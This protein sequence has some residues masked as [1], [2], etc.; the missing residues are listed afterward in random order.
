[1][2]P[3]S[4]DLRLRVLSAV[5]LGKPREEVA[6]TFSVSMPT[7]KRWLRR[8][9]ETG[10]V[11]PEPIPGRPPRKGAMLK[12]WL[13]KH[14]ETNDDLTLE[15]HRQAFEEEFGQRVS[16]STIGRAIAGLPQGGWPLKKVTHSL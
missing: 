4:K 16:T 7:I 9:R 5:E 6:K 11:D 1:M 2:K 12:E 10:D 14:L 13:P 8:R 15:E 3:Y